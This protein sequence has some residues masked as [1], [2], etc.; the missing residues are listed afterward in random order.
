MTAIKERQRRR[1]AAD[2]TASDKDVMGQVGTFSGG[3]GKICIIP[4]DLRV[5]LDSRIPS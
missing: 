1:H 4:N 2:A 3:V 5:G